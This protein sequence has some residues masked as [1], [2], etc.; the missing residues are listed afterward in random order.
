MEINLRFIYDIGKVR[1]YDI[2]EYDDK[3]VEM[4]QKILD[5]DGLQIE[6]K[7]VNPLKCDFKITDGILQCNSMIEPCPV[8]EPLLHKAM[9]SAQLVNGMPNKSSLYQLLI[10]GAENGYL[11]VN[12]EANLEHGEGTAKFTD[13]RF[14]K[15]TM[16]VYARMYDSEGFYNRMLVTYSN[17][18]LEFKPFIFATPKVLS[19]ILGCTDLKKTVKINNVEYHLWKTGVLSVY[20]DSVVYAQGIVNQACCEDIV[21]GG[22]LTMA[23]DFISG[24]TEYLGYE[25][26]K[27]QWSGGSGDY[28]SVYGVYFTSSCPK[29]GEQAREIIRRTVLN[30]LSQGVSCEEARKI[31]ANALDE[32]NCKNRTSVFSANVFAVL[33][34]KEGSVQEKLKCALE[35]KNELQQRIFWRNLYLYRVRTYLLFQR[36]NPVPFSRPALFGGNTTEYT[37]VKAAFYD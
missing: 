23:S 36:I 8:E 7:R 16:T 5:L 13:I 3:L 34:A 11:I 14:S 18:M 12:D 21:Y 9:C 31:V 15:N 33:A 20:D 4:T 37:N 26:R 22:A 25:D 17:G 2:I 28:R 1:M 35:T 6:L 32:I 24:L 29:L 19:C 30:A 10:E 27:L